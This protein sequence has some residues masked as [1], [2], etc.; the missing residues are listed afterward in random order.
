MQYHLRIARH[1]PEGGV[2]TDST[3]FDAPDVKAAITRAAA[4]AKQ[5]LGHQPGVSTLTNTYLGLIWSHRQN[6][7]EQGET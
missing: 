1:R 4:L 2:A 7:P 3:S 6:I 5:F